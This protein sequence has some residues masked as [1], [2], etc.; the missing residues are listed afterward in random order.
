VTGAD[1]A[2]A[3]AKAERYSLAADV[4]VGGPARL[5]EQ[6]SAFVE[7]GAD[8]VILGP[9]DSSNSGNAESLGEVRVLL[10]R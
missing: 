1:D 6:L 2:A 9:I 8:W 7:R 5:A 3:L 10:Q 4:L